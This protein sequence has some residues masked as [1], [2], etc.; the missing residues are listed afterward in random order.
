MKELLEL[1]KDGHAR[2]IPMLAYELHTDEAD[3]LRQI[4]FLENMG[5]IKKVWSNEPKCGGC[6]GCSGGS[7]KTC[8]SCA[9][10]GGF[11]NM[12]QMWEVVNGV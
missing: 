1:L 8:K 10:D 11:K 12:G 4:E 5:A 7:K 3:I 2:T 6:S 9:P